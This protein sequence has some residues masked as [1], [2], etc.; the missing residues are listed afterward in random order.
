[1]ATNKKTQ[2]E[3]YGEIIEVLKECKRDDLIEFVNGRIELLDKKANSRGTTALQV[4]NN[5]IKEVI[6][7]TLINLG[8]SVTINELQAEDE[9]LQVKPDGT[10]ITNQKISALLTQLKTEKKVINI[11]DKKK[12]YYKIA[13]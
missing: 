1:M 2:R 9:R 7:E 13:E 5:Q 6:I 8:R 10:K 12:S 4:E 3:F 11:K